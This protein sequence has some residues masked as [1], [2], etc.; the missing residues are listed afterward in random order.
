MQASIPAIDTGLARAFR[1]VPPLRHPAII[2]R[3]R[4]T[5]GL[6]RAEEAVRPPAGRFQRAHRFGPPASAAV[7][8]GGSLP[9]DVL[10]ENR[11]CVKIG[12]LFRC[13]SYNAFG[14][15]IDESS[16]MAD[17][18]QF[19]GRHF[20]HHDHSGCRGAS[21]RSSG[22]KGGVISVI[23]LVTDTFFSFLLLVVSKYLVS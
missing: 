19:G 13:K 4:D 10:M 6:G 23:S 8:K 11:E 18:G 3:E 21:F 1:S 17:Q 14:Y 22:C 12:N 15:R 7:L 2:S 20:D 9:V 16:Q 5:Q